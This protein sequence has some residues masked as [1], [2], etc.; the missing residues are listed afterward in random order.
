MRIRNTVCGIIGLILLCLVC[1]TVGAQSRAGSSAAAAADMPEV[2]KPWVPWVLYGSEHLLEGVPAWNDASRIYCA[3]PTRLTIDAT[4]TGAEFT[5]EWFIR[6]ES[7]I[8]L[9]GSDP[10]WP[11][12]VLVNGLPAF[13]A[14]Q[15]NVSTIRLSRGSHR[16][17][18][19][20]SWNTIPEYL[21]VPTS[22][23]QIR[24][25]INGEPAP[26]PRIDNEGRLWFRT[27]RREPAVETVE[28][29]LVM[30]EHRL[31][32]DGVPTEKQIH[33]QLNISGTSR[34]IVLGPV[35]DPDKFAL[36]NM[37][38]PFPSCFD[39]DGRLVIQARAG[40][41]SIYV[42]LRQFDSLESLTFSPPDDGYWP[43]HSVWAVRT[44]NQIRLVEISGVPAVDPHQ[45]SLPTAWKPF[46][47]YRMHAGDTMVFNELK[48][49]DPDPAPDQIS[50]N[51]TMWLRFDGSGYLMQDSITGR[52][53][54][55][56]RMEIMPPLQLGKVEIDGVVQ[57]I[58][59]RD[60]TG[61]HGVELRRGDVQMTADSELTGIISR[62]PLTGW[63]QTFQS[64]T[65][66]LALPPGYRLFHV[67]GVDNNPVT[68]INRWQL[69]DLFVVL[70]IAVATGKLF[71][72]K[73]SVLALVTMT[74]LVHEPGAPVWIFLA[75]LA[76]SALLKYLPQGKLR[77]T[78]IVYQALIV[79]I[80]VSI[81]IPFAVNHVRVGLYP[82]LDRPQQITHRGRGVMS[83][84][85]SL[86]D[87]AAQEMD[88][89]FD[90]ADSVVTGAAEVFDTPPSEPARR[91]PRTEPERPPLSVEMDPNALS[92][93]GPGIPEWTWHRIELRSGP[94]EPGRNMMILVTGP[95]TNCVLAFIRVLLLVWFA[96]ALFGV[97]YRLKAGWSV[98]GLR[99]T[100]TQTAV[101]AVILAASGVSAT[102]IP[103][104]QMLDELKTRL[105]KQDACFPACSDVSDMTVRIT[106]DE[107]HVTLQIHNRID[108]AVPL[109]GEA[110]RWVP[111]EALLNGMRISGLFRQDQTFW[112]MIPAGRHTL[113]LRGRLP[114]QNLITFPLPLKPAR[115]SVD[116]DGWTVEGIRESGRIESQL[117]FTR[118]IEES[119][120]FSEE[121]TDT[122]EA[123][124]F[125]R[126][127]R[128]LRLGLDWRVVTTVSRI[129]PQHGAIHLEIPLL[130]GESV[131]TADMDIRDGKARVH[132]PA[133]ARSIEWH[134]ILE[135]R[136]TIHLQHPDT[137]FW[138]EIWQVD[139]S[140][141]FHLEYEGIPVILHTQSN[142]MFPRWVPWPGEEVVLRISRP[143]GVEGQTMTIQRSELDISPGKRVSDC[144]LKLTIQS[145]RGGQHSIRLPDDAQVQSI[146]INGRDQPILLEGSSIP[147]G[148][149]PGNQ[150]IE[151]E[152]R[153]NRGIRTLFRT[154][155]IDLGLRHVNTTIRVQ[156]P[157]NRWL[158]WVWGPRLGPAVLFWTLLVVI[159]LAAF[160]LSRTGLTPLKFRH[161][162]LLGLGMSQAGLAV[163]LIV[164]GWLLIMHFRIKIKP[165]MSAMLFN[166]MQLCLVVITAV[167]LVAIVVA[168]NQGLLGNPVMNIAGNQSSA[169]HLRWYQDMGESALP[170]PG[171]ISLPVFVYRIAMLLWA[172]WIAFYMMTIL[173]W[174]WQ[175]FSTPVYWRSSPKKRK[176]A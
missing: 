31:I 26:F 152:W 40:Q 75:V 58:T 14:K 121:R 12:E 148:I 5:Q 9:P 3:W 128:T 130:E 118:I 18:G 163:A 41:H 110:D 56:W 60:Q 123:P 96:C 138:S 79:I 150:D 111:G 11:V 29:R 139:V 137:P 106:P 27:Q 122:I 53:N 78:A 142:V 176:T 129:S 65:T 105:L 17:T 99:R 61:P 132:I 6:C 4:D 173:K 117:Q 175:S 143:S 94:T 156:F 112:A 116:V 84:A 109:P 68:W 43:Q 158:L 153:E 10:Y 1:R 59:Q 22:T 20:I 69:M 93:T 149:V 77:K 2:L 37:E 135:L 144:R 72:W 131:T 32:I 101:I 54:S 8:T 13:T 55:D 100:L 171:M 82:Q 81:S 114:Q 157:A 141:I 119:E 167:A 98:D 159:I 42:H 15:N 107:L 168:I 63:D 19:R 46:P 64:V 21:S 62:V 70:L 165:D 83:A 154:P 120:P 91:P 23:A 115:L 136:D 161:W 85:M 7:R 126:V 24:L 28:N 151:I 104:Q 124:V 71:D 44:L 102:A 73:R 103:S 38:T 87:E 25:T 34:E 146:K 48:R 67:F 90:Y 66:S 108:A 162:L 45:T 76:G 47:A 147:I 30:Q 174:V 86:P 170:Q 57:L 52:K 33:L 164:A 39:A 97:R 166:L 155:D 89:V 172:L 92:Q 95:A 51:R 35:F 16:V 125:A 113:E 36:I 88:L 140:P 74:L 145:S 160:M 134:S 50:L 169:T 133:G 49:G 127:T 80:L